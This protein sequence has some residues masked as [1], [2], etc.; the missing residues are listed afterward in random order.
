MRCRGLR[1]KS[2]AV[3]LAGQRKEKKASA[4]QEDLGD[5]AELDEPNIFAYPKWTDY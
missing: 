3:L 4:Y 5:V 1:C 2:I